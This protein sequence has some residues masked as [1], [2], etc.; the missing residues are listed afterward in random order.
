MCVWVSVHL[1]AHWRVTLGV[2]PQ[3]PFPM[4]VCLF[5]KAKFPI[6]LELV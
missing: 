6:S 1:C 2:A 3:E 4:F 5:F